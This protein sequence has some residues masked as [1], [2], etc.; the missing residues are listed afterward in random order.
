MAT[1]ITIDGIDYD[2][3]DRAAA[4]LRLQTIACY[5]GQ[6]PSATFY[7]YGQGPLLPPH[8][9][10]NKVFRVTVDGR[11]KFAGDVRDCQPTKDADGLWKYTF[12]AEGFRARG[13]KFP[14][15]DQNTGTSLV[16]F[17]V[18][19]QD[20]AS[21]QSRQGRTVG[22]AILATLQMD[23]NAANMVQRGLGNYV[24]GS[25]A[26]ATATVAGG[27]VTG[28]AMV[29]NGS[30]YDDD[31]PPTVVLISRGSGEGATAQAVLA[32]DG[33]GGFE[34]ASI[35]V[36]D[37]GAK[38]YSAPEVVI[39]NLPEVTI[40]DLMK[41]DLIPPF[42]IQMQG[43]RFFQAIEGFLNTC[44]PNDFLWVDEQAILRFFDQTTFA[45]GPRIVLTGLGLGCVA[46]PVV[47]PLTGEIVEVRILEGGRGYSGSHTAAVEVPAGA[48]GA[49]AVLGTVTLS[50]D[51]VASIG[52]TNGGSD[53]HE[54]W[55][56]DLWH[57]IHRIDVPEMSR[58]FTACAGRVVGRSRGW[59]E[60][61]SLTWPGGGLEQRFPHSGLSNGQAIAKW[62]YS[63]YVETE[64]GNGAAR[65]TAVM[66]KTGLDEIKVI[67]GGYGFTSAPTITFSGGGG[68]GGGSA[69][70][71]V[72]GGVVTSIAIGAAG[73]Y[74]DPP[75][76]GFTGGGGAGLKAT[77]FL[78]PRAV[79]AL[80]LDD[81]GYGYASGSQELRIRG[82][83]G[84]GATGSATASGGA[85]TSVALGAG[86][87]GY[88]GTPRV[89]LQ[90]PYPGGGD[91]GTLDPADPDTDT[92]HVVCYSDDPTRTVP[93]NFWDQT[94]TGH[95][96][97]IL[98]RSSVDPT[99]D[100]VTAASI[101]ANSEM[102]PGGKMI[103]TVDHVL[104]I[105]SYDTYQIRGVDWGA[106]LVWRK[107][108]ATNEDIGHR[109][110]NEPFTKGYK[111]TA[112]SGGAG[113]VITGNTALI[114]WSDSGD[115]P[116]Y[117]IAVPFSIY[118]D[119]SV[120]IFEKP[121]PSY[122]AAPR[123]KPTDGGPDVRGQP[124][125]VRIVVGINKP[126]L[127]LVEPPDFEGDP[128]YEGTAA[129]VDGYYE[130]A[131]LQLDEWRDP[132]AE[133][134]V[135]KFLRQYL[136]SFKDTIV[137]G[138][139]RTD[140]LWPDLLDWGVAFNVHAHNGASPYMIGYEDMNVPMAGYT[141]QWLRD[142][143]YPNIV[144]FSVSNRR[145]P[146]VASLYLAPEPT[147]L[148]IGGYG[149]G[150]GSFYSGAPQGPIGQMA[151]TPGLTTPGF[152]MGPALAMGPGL[153]TGPA[154]GETGAEGVA[155]DGLDFVGGS[156]GGGVNRGRS[157][158]A[159]DLRQFDRMHRRRGIGGSS[160][161]L[162]RDP[163]DEGGDDVA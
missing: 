82:G 156:A 63:D 142:G 123:L 128:Q 40:R 62:H 93:A 133:V 110:T 130:T 48:P 87:S 101:V 125:Q 13:E 162:A 26:T 119:E 50:G 140:V 113:T 129:T 76:I 108:A 73:N 20:P 35:G 85:V 2:Q 143:P 97:D 105:T 80:R 54:A 52:L 86:G 67:D 72:S 127:V 114:A 60:G 118:P 102:T 36:T 59:V 163:L 134:H 7:L 61:V 115:P 55:T 89:V 51:A 30:G 28:I 45:K 136:D 126:G 11:V 124:N 16:R 49:G 46:R 145:A 18:P 69:T 117:E 29:S 5:R 155:P 148:E 88:T 21:I 141:A 91:S 94:D 64:R 53:Y 25:G 112:S 14:I 12:Q 116:W 31:N 159:D 1:T 10:V 160:P 131:W 68:T 154:I 98:L 70:A 34:V 96:A 42:E 135:R 3:A 41:R 139:I 22:Q 77:A 15:T 161:P 104:P 47:D 79:S 84:T 99:L 43:D 32:T 57:G 83:G 121:L 120:V 38:Y 92:L 65:V 90:A 56:C 152:S 138:S 122:F 71:T 74:Q 100:S 19:T 27:V 9:F 95:K 137:E 24:P 153:S 149:W 75:K 103:A 23:E 111:L 78:L 39:S 106:S 81:G 151:A 44:Y 58:S 17:N 4:R 37:G 144:S 132:A 109:M 8:P 66:A 157:Q 33:A 6:A 146:F 107:Y 158:R 147:G 150:S